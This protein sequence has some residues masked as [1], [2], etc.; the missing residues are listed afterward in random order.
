MIAPQLD[1]ARYTVGTYSTRDDNSNVFP[2]SP[3]GA[4]RHIA[5]DNL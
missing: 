3:H 2:D 4:Q 1:D 5:D